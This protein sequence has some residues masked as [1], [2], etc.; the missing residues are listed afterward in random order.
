MA[1]DRQHLRPKVL[2]QPLLWHSIPGTRECAPFALSPVSTCIRWGQRR[3][4]PEDEMEEML[5]ILN[6][7][8]HVVGVTSPVT[9]PWGGPGQ[10]QV[11][12]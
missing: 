10:G 3:R 8:A 1:A 6:Q 5:W 9:I 7:P 2:V 12:L 4:S 11:R